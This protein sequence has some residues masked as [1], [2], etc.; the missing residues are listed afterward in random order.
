M[1]PAAVTLADLVTFYPQT[2]LLTKYTGFSCL[3]R[4]RDHFD[5]LCPFDARRTRRQH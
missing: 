1:K 4:I 3:G 2:M 5:D